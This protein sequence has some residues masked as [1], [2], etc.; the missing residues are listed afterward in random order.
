MKNFYKVTLHR[1]VEH[2]T[3]YKVTAESEEDAEIKILEG[4]DEEVIEDSEIGD[5]QDP[6]VIDITEI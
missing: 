1:L 3:I 5:I 2:E 4:Y 6:D